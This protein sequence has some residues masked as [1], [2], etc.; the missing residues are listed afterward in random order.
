MLAPLTKRLPASPALAAALADL[1]LAAHR[2]Q[3]SSGHQAYANAVTKV[4]FVDGAPVVPAAADG[5]VP[6]LLAT[7]LTL[8]RSG[9]LDADLLAQQ[10]FYG[11]ELHQAAA[12]H[13]GRP[14][15]R[16][17]GH[18]QAPDRR[19]VGRDER[20]RQLPRPALAVAVHALVPGPRLQ[21]LR[22]RRHDRHL[23]DRRWP[24][25]CC[26]SIPFIPGL[27]DIPRLI[28]VHRLIWRSYYKSER[29]T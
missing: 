8:A 24:P 5:P 21:Q 9:A 25:C 6:A 12:V 22:Q 28:P 17:P 15:L 19:P 2:A 29:T 16:Q 26:C 27:R 14:V 13:R 4:K 1:Q 3:Q 7:E 11:T 20:D 23:H 18:S 10:P